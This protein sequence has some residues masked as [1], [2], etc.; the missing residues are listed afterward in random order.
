[1]KNLI[2][3]AALVGA[4][5]FSAFA[6]PIFNG[7]D[8]TGWTAK[9]PAELWTAKDGVLTGKSNEKKQGSVLWTDAKFKDFVLEGDFKYNGKIDSGFFLR[10][11]VDQIQIGISGSLKR[12]MTCSP[13]IAKT[14]KYPVEAK[15]IKE[16]LKIGDWNHVKIT[17]TGNVYNIE[18]NGTKV[19][20]YTSETSVPEGPIGLQ[21]HPGV[22]MQI[23][24]RNL[25]VVPA[26]K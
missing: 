3:A 4:S 10:S 20:D 6:D 21:V 14:G 12:D 18:L 11:E 1:V 26:G 24:F 2:L 25:T 17:V 15:G 19:L 22:D 13:Y 8:L 7:K 9:G 5:T 16:A 23:E